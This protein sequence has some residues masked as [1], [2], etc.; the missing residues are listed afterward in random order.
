MVPPSDL[1][2][3]RN[4]VM[5]TGSFFFFCRPPGGLALLERVT[6]GQR[7]CAYCLGQSVVQEG[8]GDAWDAMVPPSDHLHTGRMTLQVLEI[9]PRVMQVLVLSPHHTS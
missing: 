3:T 5:I 8:C 6:L 2:H 7:S 4:T 1:L 9:A